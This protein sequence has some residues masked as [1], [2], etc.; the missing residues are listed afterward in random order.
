MMWAAR[1]SPTENNK[2]GIGIAPLVVSMSE[3]RFYKALNE[4]MYE[5]RISEDR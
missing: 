4:D 5:R 2:A 3:A 1:V